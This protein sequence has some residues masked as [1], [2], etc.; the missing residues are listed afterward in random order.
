MVLMTQRKP[1]AALL[2]SLE[3]LTLPGGIA[4]KMKRRLD[5]EAKEILESD[6]KAAKRPTEAQLKAA[7]RVRDLASSMDWTAIRNQIQHLAREYERIRAAMPSGDVR[8]R[9]M[10]IVATKMRTLGLAA[11][12]FLAELVASKS[13]GE[14]LAAVTALQVAPDPE[15]LEWLGDRMAAEKPFVGYHAAVALTGAART[16][17]Q[18]HATA[19]QVAIQHAQRSLGPHLRHTDRWRELENA[20]GALEDSA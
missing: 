6:P 12:P 19:T 1:L 3:S 4:A 9:R 18:T 10:E 15:Y 17:D 5:K 2:D 14:R 16:L 11:K 20:A 13:P 8:T 7:E